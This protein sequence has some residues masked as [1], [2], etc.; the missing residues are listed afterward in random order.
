[1]LGTIKVHPDEQTH[2]LGTQKKEVQNENDMIPTID[3]RVC[4]EPR[5][6]TRATVRGAPHFF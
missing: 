3:S 1:M 5:H 2:V 6:L 4:E